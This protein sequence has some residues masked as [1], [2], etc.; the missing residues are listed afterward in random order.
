MSKQLKISAFFKPTEDSKQGRGSKQIKITQFFKRPGDMDK[1]GSPGKSIGV[2]KFQPED[3]VEDYSDQKRKV[4]T[5]NGGEKTVRN[6]P[7]YKHIPGTKFVMDAFSFGEIK[8]VER[9]FLSHFHS[10]HYMGLRK[11]FSGSLVC[12]TITGKLV[13]SQFNVDPTRIIML[14]L[15]QPK[16]IDGVKVVLVDA[17]HCPGAAIF[18][19]ILPDGRRI[20]HTGDFRA[21]PEMEKDRYLIEK[22]IDQIFLDTTYCD[23]NYCFPDQKETLQTILN[24]ALDRLKKDPLTLFACG[25][26]SIGKEKVFKCLC[27]NLNFSV[28]VSAYKLKFLKC[29]DDEVINRHLTDQQDSAQVHVLPMRDIN[30]KFLG[31]YLRGCNRRFTSIVA[32]KPTGWTEKGGRLDEIKPTSYGKIHIYGIPYSEHSSFNEL[33]RFIKFFKPK[34]I[35][36]TVNVGNP[37]TRGKMFK[38]LNSWKSSYAQSRIIPKKEEP[39]VVSIDDFIDDGVDDELAIIPIEHV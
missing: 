33:E 25:T 10:D 23:P 11:S 17:N 28:W 21:C 1:D 8:G 19:F 13:I 34:T 26:Y 32:F 6:C 4:P 14:D 3:F 38:I 27:E 30:P 29:I 36:P 35:T 16:I 12:S 37:N 7:F 9:Y 2:R 24:I 15:H 39:P 22:P 20:L 18:L 5:A 31:D